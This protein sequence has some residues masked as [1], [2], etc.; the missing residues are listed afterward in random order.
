MPAGGIVQVAAIPG[1]RIDALY[2][3]VGEQVKRGQV[4]ADMRSEKIRRGELD[5][6]RAKQDELS[7]SLAAKTLEADQAIEA[8]RLRHEQAKRTEA[9]ARAQKRLIERQI[10][11][12]PDSQLGLLKRQLATLEQVHQDPL[13]RRMVGSIELD[14]KK[15]ELDKV[16]STLQ[17]SL[18]NAENALDAAQVAVTLAANAVTAAEKSKELAAASFP[19]TSLSKQIDTLETQIAASAL[20]SP[21]DGKVLA[22]YT[23]VGELS[24]NLPLFE[25]ADLTRMIC[26]AEVHEADVGQVSIG[27]IAMME[28]A[29]LPRTI[30]GKVARI[31]PVVGSPQLRSSNPMAR[32]DFRAVTVIIEIDEADTQVAADRVQLQ[33]DVTI[34]K[35]TATKPSSKPKKSKR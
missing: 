23:D 5:T 6:L 22:R 19:T 4:L 30:R 27:D 15:S 12:K 29:G 31:D 7:Q 26:S 20:T 10:V 9:Q 8:A 18:L 2:A 24:T 21:I 14:A 11:D 25:V 17:S 28:S 32:N 1:D 35:T 13:T 16:E 34:T 3:E 33:V